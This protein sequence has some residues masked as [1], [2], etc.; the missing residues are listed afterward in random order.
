MPSSCTING[1]QKDAA[2][3]G[4][5]LRRAAEALTALLPQGLLAKPTP[6]LE[7]G[8]PSLRVKCSTS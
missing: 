2:R 8:T 7:P 6:G 3:L 4:G 1:R 5:L